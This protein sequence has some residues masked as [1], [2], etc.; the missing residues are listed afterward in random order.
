MTT[1]TV[2]C[3][4]VGCSVSFGQR[5]LVGKAAS[6][7]SFSTEVHILRFVCLIC[8]TNGAMQSLGGAS[9]ETK[10]QD[11]G[12][13]QVSE[14]SGQEPPAKKAKTE[15]TSHIDSHRMASARHHVRCHL[16]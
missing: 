3:S 5:A 1:V 8:D 12:M 10:A 9:K 2:Y 15:V 16:H 11:A 6:L 7:A 4:N 14:N 13:K